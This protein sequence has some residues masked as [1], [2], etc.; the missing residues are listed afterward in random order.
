MFWGD[1]SFLNC[2]AQLL[3]RLSPHRTRTSHSNTLTRTH[4][5]TPQSQTHTHTH[6]HTHKHTCTHTHTHTLT[7]DTR[8][9]THTWLKTA[10]D[11][12]LQVKVRRSRQTGRYLCGAQEEGRRGSRTDQEGQTTRSCCVWTYSDANWCLVLYYNPL[13][14]PTFHKNWMLKY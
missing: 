1:G 9:H 2:I 7:P 10:A 13:S 8:T 11:Y 6:T 3:F 5:L 4:T 12:I 14:K